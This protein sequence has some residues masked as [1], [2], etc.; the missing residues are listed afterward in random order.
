M[1]DLR[2]VDEV[3][4]RHRRIAHRHYA[5]QLIDAYEALRA[6]AVQLARDQ[7]YQRQLVELLVEALQSP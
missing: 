3:N 7:A 2:E 1:E 4:E 5:D 6:C